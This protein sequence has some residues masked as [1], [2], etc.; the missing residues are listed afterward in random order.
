[1]V[2]AVL[3]VL[4]ACSAM[5]RT[6]FAVAIWA[7]SI[8]VSYTRHSCHPSVPTSATQTQAINPSVPLRS[9][10]HA[11]N[12]PKAPERRDREW[13][14]ANKQPYRAID[15]SRPGAGD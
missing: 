15:R 13:L 4:S 14:I 5:D 9:E 3:I 12:G 6:V 10:G 7:C 2:S 1:M 11:V 8:L